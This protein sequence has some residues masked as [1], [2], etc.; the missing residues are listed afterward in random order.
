MQLHLSPPRE[1]WPSL[2]ARPALSVVDLFDTVRP[3]FESVEQ[4][5]D[6]ALRRYEERFD[7][8]LLDDLRVP[9]ETL[10]HAAD[11]LDASLL[12]ALRL[13]KTNIERFHAAQRFS[14]LIVPTAEGVV[15][16]QHAVPIERVGLY[17]PGGSAP[18]FSTVLMLAVPAVL[19]G[20]REIVLCTPPDRSGQVHPAILAAAQLCGVERVYRLGGAQAI[21]AMA[22]GTESVPR[23]DKIFGPGN[24]YVMA[25]KQW[26]SLH[27]VAIDMPA[28]PSEVEVIADATC[29]PAFV[30]ADLLSQAEHGSDSQVVLVAMTEAV[31]QA[32][33]AEVERQVVELPRREVAERS[34][35]NSR[36]LVLPEEK[37]VVAFTN[38]YA[39]EHLIIATER[40]RDLAQQITTAGSVFL[41]H[42][43][44]ESAGDY[45]SGTNH[46]LPTSG[47]ARAYSGLSLDSFQRKT[48]WQTLSPQ[49]VR[50]IGSCVAEMADAEQL[51]AH[52]R[53]MRL[54]MASV[55]ELAVS[56]EDGAIEAIAPLVRPNIQALAPYSCARDEFDGGNDDTVF[57]DA[58]ESPFGEDGLNRY[59]DPLQRAV[60]SK[61][62]PLK[63][64]RPGQI[65]LGNGSDEAIDLVFRV[66]CRPAVDNV[67]VLDPSYGMYEV[68][69]GVNDVE[70]RKVPLRA[71]YSFA[72]ADVLAAT[73]AQ[74]KVVF[75]CSPNNPTGNLL[76]EA[77]VSAVLRDFSGIV[78][79][80][81]AYIDFSPGS[82]WR[83]RLDR[84]PRLILLSTFSKA[85]A[86]ASIRLGMAFA[87][88][89]IIALFNKVKYPYNVNILSQRRALQLLEH[90]ERIDAE[91]Q[92]ILGERE[93]LRVAL[94][95][96]VLVQTVFPSDANFLLVRVADAPAVYRALAD[97]NII[98]RNRHR[99]TLC[100]DCL[101]IT[102]GTPEE[103]DALLCALRDIAAETT[104]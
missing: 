10:A 92:T 38:F 43:S 94:I 58:N 20:C 104:A 75:L 53:A 18:L 3:I 39:P 70:C 71:D 37:A 52:A 63:G 45:A 88:E 73:D 61:L 16:E 55:E 64:V 44:C 30:A 90:P 68:C 57:L 54:R 81:E 48:T 82:T 74:T 12:D 102:I 5:G 26:A 66:F 95:G 49:G 31:A 84:Y 1:L 59:P 83:T 29:V 41:G 11:G 69:A 2:A 85:W 22:L 35:A 56:E 99:V 50:T 24:A 65:F 72:A 89:T 13:A 76:P 14:P 19:A 93:R 33:V 7:H 36:I 98:V 21:A 8:V 46:T 32:V 28:G 25:A 91:V 51:A 100:A 42:W 23:V 17:I 78:V 86:S 79:L 40:P 77:E 97:H 47:Y 9:A 34:L 87:S 62:A 4:E 80:D 60:K 27:G 103:N 67:V 15:C 101:R 6:A 96:N